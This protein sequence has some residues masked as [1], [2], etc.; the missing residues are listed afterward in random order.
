MDLREEEAKKNKEAGR[1]D[2]LA[3]I[4]KRTMYS[5][6]FGTEAGRWVLLDLIKNFKVMDSPFSNS[7]WTAFACGEA[8]AVHYM[9]AQVPDIFYHT[10]WVYGQGEVEKL[11]KDLAEQRKEY[12]LRD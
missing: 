1:E 6:C 2:L 12:D 11:E 9:A 10:L 5:K 3:R 7:G 4:N 8:N